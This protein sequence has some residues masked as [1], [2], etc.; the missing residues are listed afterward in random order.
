MFHGR[1]NVFSLKTELVLSS[2]HLTGGVD[3]DL[4]ALD[5]NE[6]WHIAARHADTVPAAVSLLVFR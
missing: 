1:L 5:P 6:V 3:T 2:L 4:R